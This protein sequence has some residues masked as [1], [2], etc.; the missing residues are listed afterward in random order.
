[1]FKFA[2][3]VFEKRSVNELRW[4]LIAAQ[5]VEKRPKLMNKYQIIIFHTLKYLSCGDLQVIERKLSSA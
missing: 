4:P 1:M 3:F 2:V 5:V